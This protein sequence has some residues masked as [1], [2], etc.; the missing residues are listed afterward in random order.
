MEAPA[1]AWT[2]EEAGLALQRCMKNGEALG[3]SFV[4]NPG[5]VNDNHKPFFVCVRRKGSL[6]NTVSQ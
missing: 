1:L 3:V 5:T 6:G 4:H 2:L